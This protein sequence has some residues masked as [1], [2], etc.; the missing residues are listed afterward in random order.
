M[1][2]H[3]SS[4]MIRK[5]SLVL[6]L[7]VSSIV[8]FAQTAKMNVATYNLRQLNESD[9]IK[10]NG[11]RQRLPVVGS[12]IR[13][14]EFDIFGTQ[15]GFKSQLEDLKK[16]LPGYEYI[17]VAREDGHEKGEHSAIFYR[18]DLFDLL[19]KGDFWLSENPSE[20]GLG[21]DAACIRICSWGKFRH[22]PSGKEFLFFNLHMDHVGTKARIE[23]AK[24][25]RKK[26]QEIG[27]GLTSF[28][29]GDFNVDQTHNSY[30]TMTADGQLKDSF[31]VAEFVYAPNGTFNSYQTDGF[32][33]SR[34]DHIFVTPDVTVNQYGVLTDTYR[35]PL[36]GNKVKPTD[37]PAEIKIEEYTA[38]VPS[39]HFPVLIRVELN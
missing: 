16:R 35:T 36:A 14:H 26:I 29:T 28:V 20:P 34:I 32:T 7:I 27:G 22:R 2:T 33:T 17:G 13:F 12:L 1:V 15:E 38:R 11:W 31:E 21:W 39:D 25:V 18:T 8:S 24:L 30:A 10:G 6:L 9:S 37:A 3:I 23:S 19:D 5:Y 4:A